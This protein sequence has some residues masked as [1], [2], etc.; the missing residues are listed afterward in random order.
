M[1]WIDDVTLQLKCNAGPFPIKTAIKFYGT[2]SMLLI[3]IPSPFLFNIATYE[4]G[5]NR[6]SLVIDES[7]TV[8]SGFGASRKIR[9]GLHRSKKYL[10]HGILRA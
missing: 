7:T 8:N 3:D 4:K 1:L 10:T 5:R 6:L 2:L 9:E